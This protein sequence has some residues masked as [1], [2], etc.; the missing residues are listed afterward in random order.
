MSARPSPL[1]S[2]TKMSDQLAGVIHCA[3]GV[4]VKLVLPLASPTSHWPLLM[5]PVPSDSPTRQVPVPSNAATSATGV[6]TRLKLT[7]VLAPSL[8]VAVIVTGGVSG[9]WPGV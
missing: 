4:V 7:A 1:K 5:K 9:L 8:S 3:H 6:N 2:P